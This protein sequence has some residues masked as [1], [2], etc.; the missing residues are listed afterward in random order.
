M[1]RESDIVVIP[2]GADFSESTA[3]AVD[4][5]PEVGRFDSCGRNH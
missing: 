1:K 2:L 4:L 3:L 5:P